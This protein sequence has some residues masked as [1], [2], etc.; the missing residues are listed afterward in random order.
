MKKS[1]PVAESPKNPAATTAAKRAGDPAP[2]PA[3]VPGSARPVAKSKGYVVLRWFFSRA[4]RQAVDLSKQVRKILNHQRDLLEPKAVAAVEAGLAEM[5]HQLRAGAGP[6]ELR[7]QMTQLA[8]VAQDWLKAYPHAG[9]RENVEVF[10]V[11][12]AVAMAIRTFF[13]QPFKIPTGSMQPTLFGITAENLRGNPD[14]VFPTGFSRFVD[15]WVRGQSYYHV[16]AKEDGELRL[17][18]P[19]SRVL[20]FVKK[21]RFFVGNQPYTIWFPPDRLMDRAGLHNG[22]FFRRGED[23]IK[24]KVRSGDHLFVNRL[25]YNFRH[26]KRGEIIVFKTQG[27]LHPQMPQDQFYIKRLVALGTEH[28]RIGN[29]Q[30][31]II[32]GSRLDAST[33]YFENV[34]TFGPMPRE[35]EYFGHVN[36]ET[37]RRFGR[38]PGVAELFP[39]AQAEVVVRTNHYLV[40][41]DNTLN[42]FDSRG[43][44]DFS[45]SN[46]IG[47]SF[48]VYWPISDRFGWS[49][50]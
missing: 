1:Q 8:S 12:V 32:N 21:Q 45:R 2:A 22:Q 44:G 40:M 47:K 25:T 19:P 31:L 29:D 48:F 10:L 37:S 42:S 26:P 23:I 14:A 46:V 39:N 5:S 20:P 34:Y 15:S 16:V 33:P 36:E 6:V 9:F 13:L 38:P 35:N 7:K 27:I 28:V 4:V 24:L 17:N 3:P 18:E 11:A 50:R 49:H 30:H 41:G 43:W